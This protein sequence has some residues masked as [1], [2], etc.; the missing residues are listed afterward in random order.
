MLVDCR[1]YPLTH[2][3]RDHVRAVKGP[4]DGRGAYLQQLC[5]FYERHVE[6]LVLGGEGFGCVLQSF[7]G[8]SLGRVY[9][10]WMRSS[11]EDRNHSGH[12]ARVRPLV[13]PHGPTS[14]RIMRSLL[15]ACVRSHP[16]LA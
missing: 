3:R 4:G 2:L 7:A 12:E 5:E 1:Q 14:S 16:V 6:H 10:S 15:A 9:A 11:T 13:S 8:L